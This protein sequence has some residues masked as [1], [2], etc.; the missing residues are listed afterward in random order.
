[1]AHGAF[2]RDLPLDGSDDLGG[3]E[4]M[5]VDLSA[6][7]HVHSPVGLLES[8]QSSF[9]DHFGFQG[10]SLEDVFEFVA[11]HSA[12]LS[13]SCLQLLSPLSYL[14]FV[15][16]LVIHLHIKIKTWT[17]KLWGNCV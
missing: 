11:H 6:Y 15:H 16:V 7:P 2:T 13:S 10:G 12:H 1:M 8:V 5:V 3:V 14:Q 4:L 9:I 17:W